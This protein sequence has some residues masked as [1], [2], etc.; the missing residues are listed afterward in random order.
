MVTVTGM[1]RPLLEAPAAVRIICPKVEPWGKPLEF[2]R[3]MVEPGVV[4]EP[5]RIVNQELGVLR[6]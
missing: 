1:P 3:T 2:T 4:P 6:L 5:C